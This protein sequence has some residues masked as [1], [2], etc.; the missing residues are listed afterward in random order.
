MLSQEGVMAKQ[1]Q[2]G[3]R[4]D[5]LIQLFDL[6]STN[7][8]RI[9]VD[10]K[11]ENDNRFELKTTTKLGVSTA[12]DVGMNHIEKWRQ[13]NW[14]CAKGQYDSENLF[15]FE[16]IYFL[17]PENLESWFCTI[18][19]KLQEKDHLFSRITDL[20]VKYRFADIEIDQ[21][22]YVFKRGTLLNNPN[23]PWSYI[24]THGYKIDRDHAQILR[25]LLTNPPI[26]QNPTT[27]IKYEDPW[28]C[29]LGEDND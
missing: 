1:P 24:Q 6:I 20:M 22:Q 12:R 19:C 7:E 21:I 5:A 13:L 18:V 16:E 8:N 10:A 4:E 15:K 23:I 9:G 27:T 26:K 3:E 11:D 25:E 17:F 29:R 28:E 14:I 2:D